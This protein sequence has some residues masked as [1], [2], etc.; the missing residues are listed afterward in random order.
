MDTGTNIDKNSPDDARDYLN[1]TKKNVAPARAYQ[2]IAQALTF[3]IER[4]LYS[5]GSRL[6]SERELSSRFNVSRPTLR[7]ALT[8]LEAQGLV[9]IRGG[10]GTTVL[11]VPEALRG[12]ESSI[13]EFEIIEARLYFEG[14]AAALAAVFISA[15]EISTL[16]N[17]ITQMADG[18]LDKERL[19]DARRA[20]HIVIA[21]ATRNRVI[22]STIVGLWQ[23]RSASAGCILPHS[24]GQ[25]LQSPQH[26]VEHRAIVA[27]LENGD[28][29]GSR[30][31]MIAQLSADMDHLLFTTE[32]EAVEKV[33]HAAAL[34]RE[35]Y[36][37]SWLHQGY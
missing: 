32:L 3:E 36:S 7:E 37:K 33:K 16:K 9:E 17:L 30:A 21:H 18:A 2:R 8:V 25:S 5:V 10:S 6:P 28:V 1:H 20:F 19:D 23:L 12:F 14:E 34:T 29:P 22:A 15:D 27:A 13:S 31:A 4:G 11:K 35:R 24:K 26:I